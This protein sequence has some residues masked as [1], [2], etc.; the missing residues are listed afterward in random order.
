MDDLKELNAFS[1]AFADT[2]FARYPE[3]RAFAEAYSPGDAGPK[4]CLMVKV[5]APERADVDHSLV[6]YA[7]DEVTVDFDCYHCHYNW[8]P[9]FDES[10]SSL[11]ALAFIEEILSERVGVVSWWEGDKMRVSSTFRLGVPDQLQPVPGT[12]RVRRR[13]WQGNLNEDANV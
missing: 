8:P 12:T 3:W 7:D 9:D 11:N 6:I 4:T 2:L 13:S 10:D 1:R 5:P